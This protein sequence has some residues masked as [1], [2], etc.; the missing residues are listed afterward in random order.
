MDRSFDHLL[1]IM[2]I[3]CLPARQD[4]KVVKNLSENSGGVR[5]LSVCGGAAHTQNAVLLQFFY[6]KSMDSPLPFVIQ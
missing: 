1:I 2:D 3:A 5:I 6:G 4:P